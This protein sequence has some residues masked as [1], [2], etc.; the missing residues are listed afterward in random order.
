MH[1]IKIL[2][3]GC[4]N[5][6]RTTKIVKDL[7]AAEGVSATVE[8]VEDLPGIMAYGI[9]STPGVVIDEQVVHA[10]GVPSRKAVLGWLEA[11]R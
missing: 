8:K 10:G 9:M 11:L 7:V 4:R 2:G 1:I 6:Q 3:T 5:C